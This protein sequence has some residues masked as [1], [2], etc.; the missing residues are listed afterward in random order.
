MNAL[1]SWRQGRRIAKLPVV[2]LMPHSRCNCRCVMCDIWKANRNG[3]SLDEAALEKLVVDFRK[4]GVSLVALS[5]GEALMHPN[6]WHLCERLKSL[7]LKISL[8][9]S[10]LLLERHAEEIVRWCDDV[11][12][13]LDGPEATHDRIRGVQ[14]AYRA[15]KDGLAALRAIKP[16][17]PATARSVVQRSNFREMPETVAAAKDLGFDHISFLPADVSSSAFN[18]PDGWDSG[19]AGEVGLNASETAELAGV[20]EV[21]IARHRDGFIRENPTR[22]RRITAHFRGTPAPVSCNAPWVSAVV[23]SDGTVRPCFFHEPIG[24]LSEGTLPEILNSPKARAFRPSPSSTT[25]RSSRAA[26]T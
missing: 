13:S 21:V 9:S 18:R 23:E 20:I 22:L 19:R 2:T 7:P 4:L 6:L 3:T 25:A 14:G 15:T 1:S 10:G 16:D 5:G 17:F 12:V 26:C 24:D 11:I 8:L